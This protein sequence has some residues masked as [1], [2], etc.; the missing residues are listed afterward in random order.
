MGC[1]RHHHVQSRQS[2]TGVGLKANLGELRKYVSPLMSQIIILLC[3]KQ[4]KKVKIKTKGTI[5]ETT[6]VFSEIFM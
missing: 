4:V 2:T 6:A 3:E 5:L 1:Y